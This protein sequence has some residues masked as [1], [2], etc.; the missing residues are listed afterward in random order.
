MFIRK[1]DA[2][3]MALKR[4]LLPRGLLARA[5][6]IL[7]APMI[8]V[9]VAVAI[10]FYENHWATISRNMAAPVVGE[11]RAVVGLLEAARPADAALLLD[12]LDKMMAGFT[13]R[14]SADLPQDRIVNPFRMQMLITYLPGIGRPF[15]V[16][17]DDDSA[18]TTITI[19]INMKNGKQLVA[20]V[21][22]K[23]FYSTS[24][25]VFALFNIVFTAVFLAVALIFL[26]NQ[27][28]PITD[29]ARAADRFGCG[30][31]FPY[32]P[33]GA[34][35]VRLAGE[36][37]I[38]MR[39]RISRHLEERTRMLAG[40]SHDLKTPLTRMKLS[41]AMAGKSPVLDGIAEDIDE[42]QQMVHGYL[43]F[44]RG[45]AEAEAE[46]T[47]E[48]GL[49]E[50]AE[51]LVSRSGQASR[52]EIDAPGEITLRTREGPLRR[53][54][55][56]LLENALKYAP[57]ARISVRREGG[58]AVVAVDDDGPGIPADMRE[59]VFKAF[60]RLDPSRNRDTGGT[61]LGLSVARDCAHAIGGEIDLEA[62]P[63][64][65]LRAL[66][67]IPV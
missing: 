55:H 53:A 6:L 42:M 51:S 62:S 29:L 44:A 31:D 7:A 32:R 15:S 47:G 57:H 52:V 60:V 41:L 67:K 59:E 61:G 56:N 19:Y 10:F 2:A 24:L 66:L 22:Y 12:D 3:A 20:V 14:D 65:G 27:I 54:A 35:E 33:S 23:R 30:Q 26:K 28:R 50:M 25:A 8:M 46:A 13:L 49:K 40:V 16:R 58:L 1:L 18:G 38:N 39:A 4:R 64:G 9:Q 37:F 5:I 34:A 43:D 11:I 48:V 45:A 17:E 36:A 21:P 63:M